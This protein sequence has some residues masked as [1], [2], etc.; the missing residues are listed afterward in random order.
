M[1]GGLHFAAYELRLSCLFDSNCVIKRWWRKSS[2]CS[3]S[4][5]FDAHRRLV[6]SQNRNHIAA[7]QLIQLHP[8]LAHPSHFHQK[9]PRSTGCEA[10]TLPFFLASSPEPSRYI[11]DHHALLRD[12]EPR[13]SYFHFVCHGVMF[14][15]HCPHLF[16]LFSLEFLNL[17][18]LS[19]HRHFGLFTVWS[20]LLFS[21]NCLSVFSHPRNEI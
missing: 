19:L 7:T 2:F 1:I 8:P 21:L 10:A 15:L 5:L 13:L 18:P 9:F 12:L 17:E 11:T 20:G 6:H 14:L 16:H 4:R 3:G